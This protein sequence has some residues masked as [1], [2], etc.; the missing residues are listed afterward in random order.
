MFYISTFCCIKA[1][2]SS[3][4]VLL[5][6]YLKK[7]WIFNL[8]HI[9]SHISSN[10]LVFIL[11]QVCWFSFYIFLTLLVFFPL[12]DDR[13]LN[14][15]YSIKINIS[16]QLLTNWK[17]NLIFNLSICTSKFQYSH[18]LPIPSKVIKPYIKKQLLMTKL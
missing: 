11:Y 8:Y 14:I 3:S 4:E 5:R 12:T 1:R 9:Y 18:W 16:N 6:Y 2:L 7:I 10:V 15:F 17:M 13:F